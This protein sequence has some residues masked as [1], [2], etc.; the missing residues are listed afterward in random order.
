MDSIS[1]ILK[2]CREEKGYSIVQVGTD[3][4][5]LPSYIEALEENRFQDLPG[6]IYCQGFIRNLA[7]YYG[8]NDNDLM[9]LYKGES[10]VDKMSETESKVSVQETPEIE[11]GGKKKLIATAEVCALL[12]IG[13]IVFTLV[14]K[15]SGES[16]ASLAKKSTG[17]MY[18]MDEVFFEREFSEHD[19][20]RVHLENGDSDII[21]KSIGADVIFDTKSGSINLKTGESVL[22]DLDSDGKNDVK[23]ILKDINAG[24]H[25]AVFRMDRSIEAPV[26]PSL[27]LLQVAVNP[28]STVMYD[29]G[30]VII[31]NSPVK[32]NF[33]VAVEFAGACYFR[34]QV[35]SKDMVEKSY[36][37]GE[38]LKIEV[39]DDLK[40]WVSNAGMARIFIS[41]YEIILGNNGDV[42][43]ENIGWEETADKSYNLS[44]V[45]MH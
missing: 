11:R 31:L 10:C 24:R 7:K 40:L 29:K 41:S 37:K 23:I 6:K 35:D 12:L 28:D 43:C 39:S 15:L 36:K 32:S 19:T 21:C 18:I 16:D 45:S 8:L 22:L 33:I 26:P 20:I 13:V 2:G 42:T 14:L 3:T 5:I 4:H 27:P 44:I 17:T 9:A 25:T 34:Y 1:S 30:S 38:R